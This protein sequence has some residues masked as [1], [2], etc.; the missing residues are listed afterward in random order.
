VSFTHQIRVRY[1][2]CDQQGVVFHGHWLAFFDDA[3][4]R[5]FES[6]GFDPKSLFTDPGGFDFMIVEAN[7]K[8]HSPV[9]F[10]DEVS[11]TVKT[12]RIGTASFALSYSASVA[13]RSA[14]EG[15]VT[16]VSVVH[17][18]AASRP[19]PDQVRTALAAAT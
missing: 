12:E 14:V 2:D 3:C 9:R 7:L 17:G 4:T 1:S 19:I 6:L 16:Y 5:F 13:D 10:D 18:Q 15:V 8:W 11:V